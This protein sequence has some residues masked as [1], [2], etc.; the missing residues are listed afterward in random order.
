[1][2]VWC[3]KSSK[4]YNATIL[5]SG[6]FSFACSGSLQN[7]PAPVPAAPLSDACFP[8]AGLETGLDVNGAP[9]PS[10]RHRRSPL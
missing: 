1:M 3:F 4:A 9:A 10:A 6:P 8:K 7:F 2:G 5:E